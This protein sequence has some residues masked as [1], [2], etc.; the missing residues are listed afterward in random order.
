MSV[1]SSWNKHKQSKSKQTRTQLLPASKWS[2]WTKRIF[3]SHARG[4]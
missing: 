1:L 4:N 3:S 2:G